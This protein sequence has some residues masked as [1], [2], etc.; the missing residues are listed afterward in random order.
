ML[1]LKLDGTQATVSEHWA[2][3]AA[4]FGGGAY[5]HVQHIHIGGQGRCPSPSADKNGD[6]VADTIEG[7]PSFGPIGAT[8]ST[9]GDTGPASGTNLKTAPGGSPSLPLAATSPALC[10]SLMAMPASGP[11]TGMGSTAGVEDGGLFAIGGAL[12]AAAAGM[13]A[14]GRR[15]K[16]G[17]RS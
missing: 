10:G 4:T 15:S 8:L 14:F 17:A 5:P 12:L 3:L 11:D 1:T 13:F 6:G 9:S 16:A 2:G 7:Q